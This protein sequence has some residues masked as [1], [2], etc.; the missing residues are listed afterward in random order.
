MSAAQP[1]TLPTILLVNDDEPTRRILQRW[2]SHLGVR[3]QVLEAADGERGH[4]LVQAHCQSCAT[5]QSLLVLLDLQMPVLDG[6]GFLQRFQHLP[7]D[8][9]QA[10]AVVVSSTSTHSQ[11]MARTQSL[12][13]AWQPKPLRTEQLELLLHQYLPT[14]LQ[15]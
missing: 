8:C 7:L 1:S 14:A 13:T 12:A 9:Q 15:A 5:P 10:V 4:A 6:F 11:D 2:L 3:G